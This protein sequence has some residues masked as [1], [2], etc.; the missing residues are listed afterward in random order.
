[1]PTDL[2][3]LQGTWHV[4]SLETDGRKMPADALAGA[5]IVVTKDRFRSVTMGMTYGGTIEI[6]E[7]K[8][9]KMLD[10]VF[11]HGPEEGNRNLGVY[12]LAGDRWTICLATHGTTRPKTFV[13]KPGTGIALET[14]RRGAAAAGPAPRARA[15]AAKAAMARAAAA[16][17]AT[18][19]AADA[20][21]SSGTP[22]VIEGEW[23]MVSGVFSGVAMDKSMLAWAKRVTR[24][25]VTSVVAGPQVMLTA[26]FTLDDSATPHTID[27]DNLAGSNTGKAQAGIWEI[28][29]DILSVCMSAP[30][31]PR[32]KD[33]ASTKGDGR[34]FTTWRLEKK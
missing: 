11:N 9:P 5:H 23:A 17:A 14:L 2:D 7:K 10:L 19:P 30:G 34:S 1:M 20:A 15:S 27:Y 21:T 33:F 26:R 32:P 22:T 29:A 12:K 16:L 3:K 25:D 28:K 4:A 24:G 13:A 18:S 8:T 6:N 31:K